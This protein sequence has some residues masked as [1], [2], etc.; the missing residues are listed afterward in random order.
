MYKHAC[1]AKLRRGD[2]LA[3]ILQIQLQRWGPQLLS[4]RTLRP[5]CPEMNIASLYIQI[6]A[7]PVSVA[8]TPEEIS[9]ADW[10][11]L[12]RRSTDRQT[13]QHLRKSNTACDKQ[14]L[15]IN[16]LIS[17]RFQAQWTSN[18]L[19]LTAASP[20]QTHQQIRSGKSAY[21]TQE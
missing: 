8:G 12:N 17:D 21:S 1:T 5:R 16:I 20:S 13:H 4:L 11:E 18:L 7:F 14:V 2:R 9:Q 3:N 15:T 19:N 10:P 6:T